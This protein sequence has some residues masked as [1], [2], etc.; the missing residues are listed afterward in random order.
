MCSLFK[1]KNAVK[2]SPI[3]SQKGRGFSLIELIVVIGIFTVIMSVILFNQSK[4]SSSTLID[5]LAYEIALALRQ[6]QAYGIGVR[7]TNPALGSTAFAG[8]F[9]VHF[10]KTTPSTF[11]LFQDNDGTHTYTPTPNGTDQV[12]TIYNIGNNNSISD[13]CVNGSLASS[14]GCISGGSTFTTMDIT[15]TRPSPEAVIILD[16]ASVVN[17][18]A[19]AQIKVSTATH[20]KIKMVDVQLS[21]QLSVQ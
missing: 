4:L 1:N 5:N 8:G 20:D 14:V 10:D 16:G 19:S 6:A 21:G 12:L 3:I 15:Y 11:I 2:K 17:A 18:Q 9:G 13:L 7:S